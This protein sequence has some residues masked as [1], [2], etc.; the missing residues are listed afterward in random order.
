MLLPQS[1]MEKSRAS[2]FASLQGPKLLEVLT[3][4]FWL[5][6]PFLEIVSLHTQKRVLLEST[7]ELKGQLQK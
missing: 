7:E 4:S 3:L 6:L 2:F 5:L 1:L